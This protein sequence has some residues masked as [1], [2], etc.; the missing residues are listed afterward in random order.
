MELRFGRVNKDLQYNH[1]DKAK[2]YIC[3][4]VTKQTGATLATVIRDT[5]VG[6]TRDV[7][8]PSADMASEAYT[9]HFYYISVGIVEAIMDICEWKK[10]ECSHNDVFLPTDLPQSAS[11][12]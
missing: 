1:G 8:S 10:H 7:G 4:Y 11:S 6:L 9:Q 12:F 2:N 5:D 3:K